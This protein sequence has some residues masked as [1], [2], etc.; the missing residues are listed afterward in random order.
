[1]SVEKEFCDTETPRQLKI[2]VQPQEEAVKAPFFDEALR[3]KA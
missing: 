2:E 1:M 3:S